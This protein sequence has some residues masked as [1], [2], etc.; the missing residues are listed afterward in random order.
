M[1]NMLFMILPVCGVET[2]HLVLAPPSWPPLL[3]FLLLSSPPLSSPP[4]SLAPLSH[5][6][7]QEAFLPVKHTGLFQFADKNIVSSSN[8][9]PSSFSFLF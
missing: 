2:S 3:S 4:L 5:P 7:F 6:S 1:A 8:S 9:A